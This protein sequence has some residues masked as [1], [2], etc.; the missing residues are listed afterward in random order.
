MSKRSHHFI[1]LLDELART[2]GRTIVAFR[3]IHQGQALSELESVVLNAVVGAMRPPTVPQIGRSLGHAR[4]VIQRATDGL[5]ERGLIA[6]ADN[7][8]HKRARLL[9]P[10]DAG[11]AIKATADAHGLALAEA[12]T[13]GL[14]TETIVRA[15]ASLHAI[16]EVI[17]ANLR[18]AGKGQGE[19]E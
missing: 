15:T 4:Q 17:E 6:T 13:E 19:E 7:P 1:A 12:L 10:T 18:K 2:R 5:V 11:R 3:E 14:D 8:D 16:R 9:V